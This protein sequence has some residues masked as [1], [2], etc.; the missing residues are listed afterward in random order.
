M[1]SWWIILG[2][3]GRL[4]GRRWRVLEGVFGLI[5]VY[6]TGERSAKAERVLVHLTH[7]HRNDVPEDPGKRTTTSEDNGELPAAGSQ[8]SRR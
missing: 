1:E 5:A 3:A 4:L 6:T 8:A 7:S 2:F